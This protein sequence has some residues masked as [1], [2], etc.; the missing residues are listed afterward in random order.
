[1]ST[2]ASSLEQLASALEAAERALDLA[3]QER[4]RALATLDTAVGEERSDAIV[5]RL[6]SLYDDAVQRERA[7][8][9]RH[10]AASNAHSAFTL[11][12][13]NHRGGAPS[14]EEEAP[15][16]RA[17]E[18]KS[19]IAAKRKRVISNE[20]DV[21][22]S[23]EEGDTWLDHANAIHRQH[24]FRASVIRLLVG[25]IKAMGSCVEDFELFVEDL[26]PGSRGAPTDLPSLYDTLKT[27]VSLMAREH[28][29]A[30]L[31]ALELPTLE[32]G[33]LRV[34]HKSKNSALAFSYRALAKLPDDAAD[35]PVDEEAFKKAKREVE[36]AAKAA[37]RRSTRPP[38]PSSSGGHR[39]A[40][41]GPSRP[42]PPHRAPPHR[43]N[44]APSGACFTCGQ[45]G[46]HASRCPS[47]AS[48]SNP[49]A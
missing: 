33:E 17:S 18:L 32:L 23:R 26:A 44:A 47:R 35:N 2:L 34:L 15:T 39:P 8:A 24:T 4:A 48:G 5:A 22:P 21:K 43:H 20:G 36:D 45:T 42:A 31:D 19:K 11:A 1:M 38:G 29:L 27:A 40:R 14:E 9:S 13:L 3:A 30:L 6:S 10:E 16:D 46:H 37:S 49:S 12:M 7:A 41:S 25:R 28:E